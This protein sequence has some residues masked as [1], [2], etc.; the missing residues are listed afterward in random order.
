MIADQDTELYLRRPPSQNQ[1]Y[2]IDRMLLAAAQ[3]GVKVNVIVYKEVAAVLT[4]G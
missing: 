1:N 2:R 3:R 4:R